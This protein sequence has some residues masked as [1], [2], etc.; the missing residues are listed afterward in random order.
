[1]C[2]APVRYVKNSLAGIQGGNNAAAG[3]AYMKC[4][5]PKGGRDI[6]KQNVPITIAFFPTNQLD[7]PESADLVWIIPRS[8][9]HAPAIAVN[10]K[11]P[12]HAAI[13][14]RATLGS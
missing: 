7:E 3:S 9:Q 5:R 4:E 12:I 14:P 10:S 11:Q 13:S 8:A 6:A 1:M 2:P